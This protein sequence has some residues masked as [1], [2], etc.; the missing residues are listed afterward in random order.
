VDEYELDDDDLIQKI[1][2]KDLTAFQKL[3]EHHKAFVYNT[4]YNLIGNHQQAEETAQD[5]FL[6]VYKSASA[7]RHQ[8]KVSTWLYR[9]AV[10]RSLNVIRRNRRSRWIKS[11]IAEEIE[12][13]RGLEPDKLLE[14]KEMKDLLKA[15]VDSLP[16]KQRTVFILNKYENLSP[17]EIADILGVSSN[18]VEVR[19]HR[20]KINLQKK[21]TPLLKNN[22]EEL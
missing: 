18:S 3:V 4:C 19:V 11:L 15:A 13:T 8:S 2:E 10:N 12:E 7:F 9:I 16:E 21:L 22:P 17:R 20:A 6:Q 5:V 14:K 1:S